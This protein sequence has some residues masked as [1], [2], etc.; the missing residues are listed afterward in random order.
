[1]STRKVVA[2]NEHTHAGKKYYP[3]QTMELPSDKADWYCDLMGIERT[4]QRN[5]PVAKAIAKSLMGEGH[6]G[7]E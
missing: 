1:M 7:I 6:A 2:V 3:G 4:K 5:T